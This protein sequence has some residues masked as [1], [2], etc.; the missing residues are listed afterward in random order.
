MGNEQGK[1]A[2][3]AIRPI[4]EADIRGF[5]Q[6]LDSVAKERKYLAQLEA[7]PMER[8]TEFVRAAMR[9]GD[10]RVVALSTSRVV[11]WCDITPHHWKGLDHVGELG[12]GVLKAYRRRGIGQAL[13]ERAIRESHTKGLEKVEL[14]VFASN[15]PAIALYEKVG[16]MVEGRRRK[17][18]KL[19]GEYDDII[20]MGLLLVQSD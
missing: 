19:D 12:M 5:R 20:E 6:C 8:V 1:T 9:R 13:L 17:S 4:T 14:E 10:T 15:A 11:G 16:F 7:P 18:R 3:T 2:A